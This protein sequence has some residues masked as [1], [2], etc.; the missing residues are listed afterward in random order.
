MK[1]LIRCASADNLKSWDIQ[2][3]QTKEWS[4]IKAK[5]PKEAA[6]KVA[7]RPVT[8]TTDYLNSLYYVYE[9]GTQRDAYKRATGHYG[10]VYYY[11]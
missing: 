4:V 1:R 2:D 3:R 7:G 8:E 10:R 11:V 9:T 6:E 5:G